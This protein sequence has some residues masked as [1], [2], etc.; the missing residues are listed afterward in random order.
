MRANLVIF[1]ELQAIF[2]PK[3]FTSLK[4]MCAHLEGAG[5]FRVGNFLECQSRHGFLSV[6]AVAP[7]TGAW[8]E[9][10]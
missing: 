6:F 8:I 10:T 3:L 5:R 1:S 9:S 4:K 7:L 2:V